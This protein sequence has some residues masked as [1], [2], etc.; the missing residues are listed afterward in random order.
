MPQLFQM[1]W[2]KQ[3][4]ASL[5]SW[6]P[7]ICRD[8]GAVFAANG[9]SGLIGVA[10]VPIGIHY[11]GVG[12]YGVFSI[13]TLAVSYVLLADLGL[14]KN[15]LRLLAQQRESAT[16]ASHLRTAMGLYSF[17]S[18]AW[19]LLLPTL[20]VVVPK[21]VFPVPYQ[22]LPALRG[23]IVCSVAEFVLGIPQSIT[24]TVCLAN[25]NFGSYSRFAIV[26]SILRNTVFM[27]GAMSGSPLLTGI[28]MVARKLPEFYLAIR[29]MGTPPRAAWRPVWG[30]RACRGM[31]SESGQLSAAQILYSTVMSAGSYLINRFF[32]LEGLGTYRAAF[33]LAGKVAFISNGVS[34][35]VFPRFAALLAR[36]TPRSPLTISAGPAL[37]VS[38]AVYNCLGG[39]GVILAPIILPRIAIRATNA[40]DSFSL[41]IV[42]L[43]LNCHV[44]LSNE[45]IQASGR[46]R[47]N[48]IV[49]GTALVLICGTFF[50]SLNAAG[51]LAIGI[52]W[53]VASFGAAVVADTAIL[54]LL[55][56]ETHQILL[57]AGVKITILLAAG[58]VLFWHFSLRSSVTVIAPFLVLALC[59]GVSL[60]AFRRA[61]H[62]LLPS[63]QVSLAPAESA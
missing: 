15:L 61:Y 57:S 26:S 12:G 31:V 13:Y 63:T 46:Y 11:L 43:S 47:L 41:L 54:R 27:L 34:L 52:A 48:M 45:I 39:V 10:A 44:L 55:S 36:R 30:L 60:A 53:I 3:T 24:Q 59:L 14:S 32:G 5:I 1:V 19:I 25:G 62:V 7:R 37:N 16:Q 51:P 6:L 23:L 33:D 40:V 49:S 2:L 50:A 9:V 4:R 56:I 42:G 18:V 35:V 38:W 29:M 21:Y 8:L 17:L 28:F 22:F 20:L 58:C